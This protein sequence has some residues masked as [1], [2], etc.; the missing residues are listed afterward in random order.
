MSKI[1]VLHVVPTLRAGGMEMALSRITNGLLEEGFSH[2]IVVLKGEPIIQAMFDPA[3]KIHCVR[4]STNS[5]AVSLRLREILKQERPSVIH[6]RNFGAWPEIAMARLTVLPKVPLIF[7]FHGVTDPA[8]PPWRWR[9]TL[10]LMQTISTYVYA[11]S[12]GAKAYLTEKVGL[13]GA[14]I[15]VIPNGVDT[16]RFF[17]QPKTANSSPLTLGTL[18]S[19]TP[20]KNQALLIRAVRR[21]LETGLDLRLLIAGEGPLREELEA[22]IAELGVAEQV[23]LVGQISDTPTFL[24]SLDMFVLPSN[25]EAHPNALSEAM[26]CGLPCIGSRV[27]GIPEILGQGQAG[28]LFEVGDEAG[29]AET[30]RS[31]AQNEVRRQSLGQ[32][33]LELTLQNYSLPV[34]LQRYQALYRR[35]SGCGDT[36]SF[37]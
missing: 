17:P 23:Q 22:L 36:A 21:L 11:V 5:F 6:A 16:S 31:L 26:A 37:P 28:A 13:S 1:H 34:M 18:G 32:A 10:R 25:S 12:H 14:G 24:H 27:G 4:A 2:S 8:A 19:L 9:M 30:I 15:A 33:A 35:F 29:L 7:S 20:V 3:I